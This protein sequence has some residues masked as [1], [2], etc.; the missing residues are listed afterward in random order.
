ML[1]SLV[2]MGCREDDDPSSSSSGGYEGTY[3][4][5]IVAGVGTQVDCTMKIEVSGTGFFITISDGGNEI[6]PDILV[7][8]IE[9]DDGGYYVVPCDD[10]CYQGDMNIT[11]GEL[12]KVDGKVS[13]VFEVDDWMGITVIE[14]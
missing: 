7:N 10:Y 9:G 14:K 12:T 11:D 6:D 8:V 13:L 2:F 3:N 1:S 5:K 4:S